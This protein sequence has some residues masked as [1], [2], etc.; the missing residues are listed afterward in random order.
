MYKRIFGLLFLLPLGLPAAQF[1]LPSFCSYNPRYETIKHNRGEKRIFIETGTA[2]GE[3]IFMAI[4]AGFEQIYSVELDPEL[5][6]TSKHR[7]RNYPNVHLY[8]GDSATM[9]SSLLPSITEPALFWLDAHFAGEKTIGHN[10]PI[11]RELDAIASHSIK[12][13]TILVDDVRCFGSSAYDEITINEVVE[14]IKRINPAYEISFQDG[15]IKN[16]VLVAQIK[17]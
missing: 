11:L 16:D 15:H 2:G 13:H 8:L 14:A 9:L 5:H 3:G 17:Y 4:Y 1:P 12:T 10:C 7:T 6:N